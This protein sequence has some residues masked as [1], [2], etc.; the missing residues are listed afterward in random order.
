M[1]PRAVRDDEEAPGRGIYG[2]AT[3]EE[4]AD[5]I[6]DGIDVTPLPRLPDDLT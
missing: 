3:R 2:E 4:V 5:L 6:E 1:V